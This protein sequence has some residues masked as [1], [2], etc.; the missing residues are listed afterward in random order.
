MGYEFTNWQTAEVVRAVFFP[1]PAAD[2]DYIAESPLS[3]QN[4][5][6]LAPALAKTFSARAALE[7][8][9][10]SKQS[11]CIVRRSLPRRRHLASRDVALR[12][13]H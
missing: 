7:H 13:A 12:F 2:A 10:C 3:A 11:A 9:G 4:R 8:R 1:L 5:A 6:E